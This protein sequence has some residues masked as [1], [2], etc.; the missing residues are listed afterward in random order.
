M[1]K[2]TEVPLWNTNA[3]NRV[4][5]PIG[6]QQ[7]GHAPNSTPSSSYENWR[8]GLAGDWCQWVMDGTSADDAT[9]HIVETN[10]QGEISC[11]GLTID[12]NSGSP[13]ALLEVVN[14][15]GAAAEFT[16][17]GAAPTLVVNGSSGDA[18][19]Y[20]E[21]AAGRPAVQAVG[22]GSGPGVLANA[23]T[24]H[25]GVESAGDS[26][27]PGVRVTSAD[28]AGSH[29][30]VGVTHVDAITGVYGIYAR[31]ESNGGTALLGEAAL[32][33]TTAGAGILASGGAASGS[34][35][36]ALR[37]VVVG[38]GYACELLSPSSPGRAPLRPGGPAT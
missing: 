16:G 25:P 27:Q 29:G 12:A 34:A 5:P 36:T 28:D 17:G 14:A 2:P 1:P 23:G 26:G 19:L 31:C 38:T 3:T 21:A 32:A 6:V 15:T 22:N 10:A 7:A 20:V 8:S 35:A 37:A 30:L 18:S 9:A 13:A 24:G 11:L 33:G 4:N